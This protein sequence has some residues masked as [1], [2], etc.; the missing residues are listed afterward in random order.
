MIYNFRVDILRNSIKIGEALCDSGLVSFDK[1][2]DVSLGLQ[3]SMSSDRIRMQKYV[4]NIGGTA[5][6]YTFNMFSDRLRPV[7]IKNGDE[8]PL[9]IYMV[10]AS[11][12]KL[13][14]T[15]SMYRIEAY[16]ETMILKQASFTSRT[17]YA[18]GTSYLEVI[19]SML[20]SCGFSRILEDPTDAVL[21]T[22]IEVAPGDTYL[23]VINQF[24]DGINYEH[25]HADGNGYIYIQA[26]K[27]KM[28][29]DHIYS[30]KKNMS[31]IPPI[32]RTTDIYSLPNVITGVVSLP[33]MDEPMV[34]TKEN[35][36]PDSKISI[37][38]RGY[39]VV[40]IINLNNIADELTLQSYIDQKYYEYSQITE[41]IEIDTTVE[42]D[43]SFGD[44]V[45]IDSDLIS[46][47]YNEIKWEIRLGSDG[48]MKHVLERKVYV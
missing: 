23:E 1:R 2:A 29:A 34:Y 16:D 20:T 3:L 15:E 10:M 32:T 43:H 18:A 12:E 39:R 22:D 37:P 26:I 45:Q 28:T 31:I 7:L 25:V 48:A 17:N 21:Q 27:D 24:L 4:S 35:L 33:E 9:G 30:D 46:G 11:P 36:N 44:T 8:Y 5:Q 42:G 41:Q 14:D 38:S 47:L 19:N 13:S 40:K 6:T